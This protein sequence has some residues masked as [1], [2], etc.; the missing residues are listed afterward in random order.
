MNPEQDQHV[1]VVSTLTNRP[2][3]L[4]GLGPM[5]FSNTLGESGTSPARVA[6]ELG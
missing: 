2:R 4:V 1:T 6:C 3:C 5:A